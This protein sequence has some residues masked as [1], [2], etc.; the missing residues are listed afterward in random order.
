MKPIREYLSQLPAPYN[1]LALS[2]VDEN[3]AQ[4]EAEVESLHKAI[5]TMCDWKKT[6]QGHNFWNAIDNW[7]INPNKHELPP[8]PA[9]EVSPEVEQTNN[10]LEIGKTFNTL[11]EQLN[12][13]IQENVSLSDGN[14]LY[15]DKIKDLEQQNSRYAESI[16]RHQNTV[17]SQKDEIKQQWETINTLRAELLS[18]PK[19][20]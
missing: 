11:S 13:L 19:E 16:L 14:A 12:S 17:D 6:P 10:L 7:C 9:V 18:N 20:L 8:I 1:T 5:Y 3:F 15:Q 2:V 4:Y